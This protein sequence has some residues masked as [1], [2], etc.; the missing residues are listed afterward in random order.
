VATSTNLD[1]RAFW[2]DTE[3]GLIFLDTPQ[4]GML[5]DLVEDYRQTSRRLT[6]DEP[7]HPLSEVLFNWA[8]LRSVF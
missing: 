8:W 5:L 1:H 3:N 6:A 2:H 7:L 4:V